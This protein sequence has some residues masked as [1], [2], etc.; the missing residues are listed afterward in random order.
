MESTGVVYNLHFIVCLKCKFVFFFIKIYFIMA[1]TIIKY[2]FFI[3]HLF[4][5]GIT[6]FLPFIDIYYS[7]LQF[8]VILSWKLNKNKCLL[9][10]M[11]NLLFNETIVENYYKKINKNIII[12]NKLIV[13]SY[14]RYFVYLLFSYNIYKLV[15]FYAK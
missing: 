1:I 8:I 15:F 13:P 2:I 11:E 6:M 7:F 5:I 9:T 14:Q 10:Q 3:L 4:F 12:K